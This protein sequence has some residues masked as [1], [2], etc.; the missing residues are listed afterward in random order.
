[1]RDGGLDLRGPNKNPADRDMINAINGKLRNGADQVS[2]LVDP[3]CTQR[4]A[5][6]GR[7]RLGAGG[8]PAT[9]E[10]GEDHFGR[11]LGYLVHY[12]YPVTQRKAA[13]A[14]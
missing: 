8:K 1:M 5:S 10:N 2:L 6:L 12:L 13:K 7:Q 9:M 3:S 14:A 4:I 11:A